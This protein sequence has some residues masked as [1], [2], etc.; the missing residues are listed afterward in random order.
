M[1]RGSSF[2]F[3]GKLFF[4][5]MA[6]L[7]AGF[8]WAMWDTGTSPAALLKAFTA[9]AEAGTNSDTPPKDPK[10]VAKDP[11]DPA[12][13]PVKDPAKDP[14]K[15]PAKD[16]KTAPKETPKTYSADQMSALFTGVAADLRDG[17]L[18][19]ARDAVAKINKLLG[20]TDQLGPFGDLEQRVMRY[21]GLVLETTPGALIDLP[22]MCHLTIKGG[23]SRGLYVKNLSE[24]G[25]DYRFETLD[26]IRSRRAKTEV[27]ALEKLDR[28]R[29]LAAVNFELER[30]AG[31]KGIVVKTEGSK[32]VLETKP[33]SKVDGL[34]FFELA[35]F[36][37][38]NGA[39]KYLPPLFDRACELDPNIIDTVHENKADA[40]V[41]VLIY[42]ISIRAK[43]DAKWTSDL[44]AKRYG[45][46]RAYREKIEGDPEIKS[47]YQDLF[48]VAIAVA[49]KPDPV[50]DPKV[51]PADP[52]VEDPPRDPDPPPPDP[53]PVEG[54]EPTGPD[55]GATK[56]PDDAPAKAK[57]LCREG[58]K[59]YEEAMKHLLNS[60]PNLNRE[61]W[62]DE[63]KKA[64]DFFTKAFEAYNKAQDLFGSN[65]PASLLK[66]FR[67]TQM[68]RSLCRKRS[69]STKK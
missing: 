41:N 2:G 44:L 51:T 3:G 13:D 6:A 65:V 37:A 23:G 9:P 50:K 19:A 1:A 60:D 59:Q 25:L 45:S 17:K 28:G 40:L 62:S 27:E 55:L 53:K 64:L 18:R 36:C 16:P 34:A 52:K 61:G 29:G 57:E 15:D 7:S 67:E 11:V 8:L 63:N 66:R 4:C 12:K 47:H 58:D 30:K 33:G 24:A 35:D 69:V 32:M 5:I 14:V 68:S 39:N 38:R 49:P 26:G 22:E 43:E 54:S 21:W 46:T 42:F 48:N 56:L 31:Y 10:T 20:P